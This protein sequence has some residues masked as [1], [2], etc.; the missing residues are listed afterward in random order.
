MR[1]LPGTACDTVLAV[2]ERRIMN[3]GIA[4]IRDLTEDTDRAADGGSV[5]SRVFAGALAGQVAGALTEARKSAAGDAGRFGLDAVLH[6]AGV[7]SRALAIPDVPGQSL[8]LGL[9]GTIAS[10]LNAARDAYGCA[11]RA[12]TLSPAFDAS[13]LAHLDRARACAQVLTEHLARARN[14]D[15]GPGHCTEITRACGAARNRG[16]RGAGQVMP[17]TARLLAVAALMLPGNTGPGMPRSTSASCG[18]SPSP[19]TTA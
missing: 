2:R 6:R 10:E 16:L 11:A 19:V 5:I 18:I 3:N 12:G 1:M 17:G 4:H 15:A 8:P 7:L 13:F 9:A 14:R